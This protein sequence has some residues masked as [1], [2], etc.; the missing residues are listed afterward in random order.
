MSSSSDE[1]NQ[2]IRDLYRSKQKN[3]FRRLQSTNNDSSDDELES[4][5]SSDDGIGNNTTYNEEMDFVVD[6]DNNRITVTHHK[7]NASSNSRLNEKDLSNAWKLFDTTD[8]ASTKIQKIIDDKPRKFQ[9]LEKE[10]INEPLP[11][12]FE[13]EC[14]RCHFKS[15]VIKQTYLSTW[16][17]NKSFKSRI[18]TL[19]RNED[20]DEEESEEYKKQR[21]ILDDLFQL[22]FNQGKLV[23]TPQYVKNC[24]PDLL[25]R[26][27]SESIFSE[28]D[29]YII[30][31]T[32]KKYEAILKERGSVIKLILDYIKKFENE[33]FYP[34]MQSSISY[35]D[36][37]LVLKDYRT[38]IQIHSD[39]QKGQ[40][41]FLKREKLFEN[42]TKQFLLDPSALAVKLDHNSNIASISE[43]P[44]PIDR[45]SVV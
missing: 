2:V 18:N 7:I 27:N 42:L 38:Y 5:E 3:K 26:P 37:P 43:P 24:K 44:E 8:Q 4:N 45:K 13:R 10:T 15:N 12:E 32:C 34:Y 28:D 22:M 1:D 16:V 41:L 6:D 25:V 21:Q 30:L 29:I 19:E 20:E 36:D 40:A 39:D 17:L 31:S 35:A 14:D 11:D 23:L 9:K 33:E